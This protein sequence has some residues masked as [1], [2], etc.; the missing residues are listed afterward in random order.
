M[1]LTFFARDPQKGGKI[2]KFFSFRGT[3]IELPLKKCV[4]TRK[5]PLYSWFWW[6]PPGGAGKCNFIKIQISPNFGYFESNF[7]APRY[8]LGVPHLILAKLDF[9]QKS[10]KK[11]LGGHFFSI[12]LNISVDI[13]YDHFFE[14]KS[15]PLQY[16]IRK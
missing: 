10:R 2:P 3:P 1:S 8:P 11:I 4:S 7:L 6:G 5:R 15:H 16:G 9:F 14:I 13:M 12:A